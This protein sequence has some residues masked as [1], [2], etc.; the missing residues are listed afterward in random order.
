MCLDLQA[1]ISSYR[2]KAFDI[3][4]ENK[5]LAK[6]YLNDSI[7]KIVYGTYIGN[8]NFNLVNGSILYTDII[9]KPLTYKLEVVHVQ[10]VE[11]KSLP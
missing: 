1:K 6:S 11:L 8:Y 7:S 10:L 3:W 4:A 5:T 2:G 9:Q